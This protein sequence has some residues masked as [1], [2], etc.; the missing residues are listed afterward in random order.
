MKRKG[1]IAFDI[2]IAIIVLLGLLFGSQISSSRLG[3]TQ[4]NMLADNA[5]RNFDFEITPEYQKKQAGETAQINVSLKSANMGEVGVNN[6]VGYFT[7]DE[8]IFE[9]ISITTDV[10]WHFEL[11]QD[12]N[13]EMYRKFVAYTMKEGVTYAPDMLNIALKLRPDVTPQKTEVTFTQIMSSDGEVLVSDDDRSAI[14]EIYDPSANEDE[15]DKPENQDSPENTSSPEGENSEEKNAESENHKANNSEAEDSKANRTH[16]NTNSNQINSIKTGDNIII[17]SLVLAVVT[18]VLN[19]L[20]SM[21]GSKSNGAGVKVGIVSAIFVIAINLLLLA[22][23]SF[24]NNT[25][26][27]DLISRLSHNESWLNSEEYLVTDTNISRIRPLTNLSDFEKKFNKDIEV[28]KKDSLEQVTDGIIATGM[29]AVDRDNSYETIVL[30]DVNGDGFS[31]GID[32]TNIIRLLVNSDKY[33]F[34][35]VQRA[36]ADITIDNSMT[37]DDVDALVEHILYS[38]LNIPEFDNVV[39]P[40]I[41]IVGGTFNNKIDA[42]EDNVTIKITAQDSNATRTKYKIEGTNTKEYTVIESGDTFEI[43][44]NGVY[45]VSAY[46]YGV[47]GNRSEIPYEI[48]VKKH[49]NNR[50]KI[51]TRAENA[52]G[53]YQETTEQ[54]VARIGDTVT[55]SESIVPE[56]YKLNLA[57]SILE[58]VVAEDE[59]T[60]LVVTLDRKEYTLTLNAGDYISS[61]KIGND[62]NSSTISK[63]FKFGKTVDISAELEEANG[64]TTTFDRWISEDTSIMSDLDDMNTQITMPMENISYTANARRVSDTDTLYTVEYYYQHDGIYL[65]TPDRSK[66][67]S[68]ETG[69]SVEVDETDKTPTRA[70]YVLDTSKTEFYV[71][72]VDGNGSL[73]L[74]VYFKQ[75]LKVTYSK[76]DHGTFSNQITEH[77]AWGSDMPAF[78]GELSHEEG[79]DFNGW[80]TMPS[81]KV[82]ESIEYV[83]QWKEHEY[84]ITYKL[85]GGSLAEGITNR[86]TY[87]ISTESFTLNNPTKNGYTFKGWT[88]TDLNSESKN[89][90]VTKGSFGDRAYEAVWEVIDYRIDYELNDGSL[91]EDD[92]GNAI[93]NPT[94]YNV[95]TETFILKNPVKVGYTFTGWTG[96][97]L[98]E[99]FTQVTITKGSTGDRSFV[100]NW[101]ANT[102]VEYKVRYYKE[103]LESTDSSNKENYALADEKTKSATTGEDVTAE[104]LELAGFTFDQNNA[105]NKLTDKLKGDGSLILE[106][107]YTR[108]SYTLTLEKDE[109][110]ENVTGANTYK[111]EAPVEIDASLKTETGYEISFVKWTSSTSESENADHLDDIFVKNA[112]FTMPAG[113]V[114][115]TAISSKLANEVD[116]TVEF[117]YEENG[118]YPSQVD[119][120]NRATRQAQTDTMVYVTDDDK[121]TT[122]PT[123]VFDESKNGNLNGKVKGDGSLVLKVYF[124]QEFTVTYSKGTHGT[125]DSQVTANLRY[126]SDTPEFSGEKTHDA[127]YEFTSW[128]KTVENKVTNNVEYVAE[129]R[130]IDYTIEYNLNGGTLGKDTEQNDITNKETYTV[131]TETFTLNNPTKDGYTFKGWTGTGINNDEN[132]DLTVPQENVTVEQGS[133]GNRAYVANWQAIEYS[134]TYDLDGGSLGKDEEQNDITNPEKYTIETSSF[135]L[136]NPTKTGYTF[137]G[138]TGTGIDNIENPEATEPQDSVTIAQGSIGD[139][140]YVAKWRANTGVVYHVEYYTE[141]LESTDKDDANN[142]TLKENKELDGTTAESVTAEIKSFTGF[143]FDSTNTNNVLSGNIAGNGSLILKV[144]YTRNSYNLTM[145]KDD[146][147]S[148]VA[149][150][151][152]NSST[153]N[154][155][156]ETS[157]QGTFKFEEPIQVNATVKSEAGYT[158]TFKEWVSSSTEILQ[159]EDSKKL[160]ETN[161]TMPAE[162]V[163]VRA[164]SNRL[165][166]TV[167]YRVEYYYQGESGYPST[168]TYVDES[169]TAKVDTVVNVTNA[170]KTA[171]ERNPGF[172]FDESAENVLSATIP[173]TGTAVLK[174]YFKEALFTVNIVAGDKITQIKLGDAT[175]GEGESLQATYMY[176]DTVTIDATVGEQFGYTIDFGKWKS[177]NTSLM[178][179]NTTKNLSFTMPD[180]DITL[181]A[182]A[183]I[184][185]LDA[186]YT[187]EYYYQVSGVYPDEPGQNNII[188]RTGKTGQ[189]ASITNADKEPITEG[190]VYDTDA[191][192]IETTDE[193]GIKPDG[194]TVLKVYFKEQFKVS[195]L[196]GEHGNF[197]E[198]VIRN[199]DYNTEIPQYSGSTEG[200]D[201]YIFGGWKLTKIGNTVVTDGTEIPSKV[202]ANLEYTAQWNAM[203][204]PNATHTPTTW[205]NQSTTVSIAAP[206]GFED[207]SIEYRVG[208]STE[209]ASYSVPFEVVQNCTIH[210][211]IGKGDNKGEAV[212]YEIT[213]V[214][215]VNPQFAG[216]PTYE[217]EN[218]TA[219]VTAN[220]TDDLSGVVQYGIRKDT[221]TGFDMHTCDSTLDGVLTFDGVHESGEYELCIK[222]AA[223]NTNTKVIEIEIPAHNVA[224]IASA[225]EGFESLVGTEY[226]TLALALSSSDEAAQAGNV[227][228]QIINHIDNEENV[229]QNGRNY[230]INLNNYSVKNQEGK[231]AMTVSGKLRLVDEN[232]VG[233]GTLSSPFGLG[234]YITVDGE[235]TLGKDGDG[236]PSVFSPVV[237]GGT[238]GVQKE[239]DT[240]AE[241]VY[242][243]SKEAYYYPEGVFNFYDGKVVGGIAAFNIQRV[244]D[245]PSLFDPTVATNGSTGEQESTLAMV[246]GVEAVIGRRRYSSLEDAIAD[247]NN[248]V[249]TSAQQV[250]ISVVKD[251]EKDGNHKIVVDE[252]KNIYG[253]LRDVMPTG[254]NDVYIID[255]DDGKE[256]LLPA[257][258]DCILNVDFDEGIIK[259]HILG[260]LL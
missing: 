197:D 17:T 118:E 116:Y 98:T 63:N 131:E 99:Q 64:Y 151:S 215:K 199:K 138:W 94:S 201:G 91:G 84:T 193:Q 228:I 241:K 68:G 204:T 48:I 142:Y 145:E 44:E 216:T 156:D 58:G 4:S 220:I 90:T 247:A 78:D 26:T 33:R 212:D 82:T 162:N 175:A 31:D 46:S 89:V 60:E 66:A 202:V 240:T 158:I 188:E 49:P 19:V 256:L 255:L 93:T 11:N 47:L 74:K 196:P 104:I 109:N 126:N 32:L 222:D 165:A 232:V 187:I 185:P 258:K 194:T 80:S 1:L 123:Y 140:N 117:Y 7:Y 214:D 198:L 18:F 111:F 213:N 3:L 147:I 252:T 8:N 115:L 148:S 195:Y 25:E 13:H 225:P 22:V 59:I 81:N 184:T 239:I 210:A 191:N 69:A 85:H 146:Y 139:R 5:D 127:G 112:V 155:V 27:A 176:G 178:A 205:T 130:A 144:Y 235:F 41:E 230:T 16:S 246:S 125:F 134:I 169:R 108:N 132:P 154:S 167:G 157:L 43:E 135:T 72:T 259:I 159:S 105:N 102:G 257:I 129:W 200:K 152:T 136:S 161:F 221:Y 51:I 226:E 100:A 209:W 245:S 9:E 40:K 53:T 224:K 207:Y 87:T 88:G 190:Y 110:V 251:L 101:R 253:V 163:T 180:G 86:D 181:T 95:D 128:D 203:P 67:K 30:G 182:I 65:T 143:T 137:L 36:A 23:I 233:S 248:R 106:L 217:I 122:R 21:K 166:N 133:I 229:I 96:T 61:V 34:S 208:D 249:G 242:D 2:F 38:N 29:R 83:A 45:K 35:G 62:S 24:A 174:V 171:D 172:R 237:Q 219:V 103:K 52:D 114:T 168:P 164:T 223:G 179:D 192:N 37:M 75:D 77:L 39:E 238:Y 121:I 206:E 227:K 97:D 150:V 173:A 160:A 243:E 141:K 149:G 119:D 50:Y 57:E 236:A 55:V 254:A 6:I 120:L 12:K 15:P 260:G 244:N 153:G 234:V 177:S 183:N 189:Q 113:D 124:K 71:G 170:D 250:E 70:D 14:I 231:T 107:Y 10:D 42:Y 218:D 76:G 92:L 79:Y 186:T 20:I 73:V 54:K 28:Y 56:G 211:R